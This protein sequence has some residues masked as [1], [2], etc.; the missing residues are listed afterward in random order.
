[1]ADLRV[2]TGSRLKLV[3]FKEE[4]ICDAYIGWLNDPDVNR[5]MEVRFVRQTHEAVLAYVQSFYGDAEK[6]MWGVYQKG[7]MFLNGT[8]TLGYISR[9][10]RRGMLGMM[11]GDK[12]CWSKGFGTEVIKLIIDFAFKELNLHK[13]TAGAIA[14]NLGSIKAFQK[15]GF[16]IE[17][18][19]KS[20]DFGDGIFRDS[21]YLGIVNMDE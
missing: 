16:E 18:R 14:D 19:M 21:V 5:F 4:H 20:H 10:H 7:N 12:G 17:G 3:P 1:M 15:A 13:V 11:I 2:L 9:N 6:Y 8:A